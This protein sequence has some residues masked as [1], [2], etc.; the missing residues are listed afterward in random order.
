[1][2][3]DRQNWVKSPLTTMQLSV[4]QDR[5]LSFQWTIHFE[6]DFEKRQKSLNYRPS[7]KTKTYFA[8][9]RFESDQMLELISK[10]IHLLLYPVRSVSHLDTILKGS[11]NRKKSLCSSLTRFTDSKILFLT[12][13][14]WQSGSASYTTVFGSSCSLANHF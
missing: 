5:Q 14:T 2:G 13:L 10:F 7:K 6:S 4:V 11:L 8:E 1:M 12:R 9:K 3:H